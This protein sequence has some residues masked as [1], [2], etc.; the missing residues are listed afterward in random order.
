MSPLSSSGAVVSQCVCK[1]A[2]PWREGNLDF[3]FFIWTFLHHCGITPCLLRTVGLG[4]LLGVAEHLLSK[5]G[6]I[7]DALGS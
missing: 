1:I 3:M 7:H 5:P 6:A 2:R 4:W